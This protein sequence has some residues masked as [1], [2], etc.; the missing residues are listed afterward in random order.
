MVFRLGLDK[1][2]QFALLFAA[3]NLGESF[4]SE[5]DCDRLALPERCYLVGPPRQCALVRL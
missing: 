3:M 2:L 5:C 4:D 1:F